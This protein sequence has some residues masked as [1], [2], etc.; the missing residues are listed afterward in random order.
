MEQLKYIN[1]IPHRILQQ[2]ETITKGDFYLDPEIVFAKYTL[3]GIVGCTRPWYRPTTTKL[4]NGVLCRPLEPGEIVAREDRFVG[5]STYQVQLAD[6]CIGQPAY[7]I[8]CPW[9]RPVCTP[10]IEQ[11]P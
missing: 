8:T 7:A 11:H 6:G 10:P 1:G 3:S 5:P 4:I 9:Y 2:G